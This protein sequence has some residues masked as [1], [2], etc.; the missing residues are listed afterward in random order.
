M[1]MDIES[2]EATLWSEN[3]RL[4]SENEHLQAELKCALQSG[5]HLLELAEQ[6]LTA[7]RP[8]ADLAAV[9]GTPG[10]SALK[11]VISK[12]LESAPYPDD[13][14]AVNEFCNAI[15][16]ARATLARDHQ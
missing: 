16:T 15:L 4:K 12:M 2:P 3:M 11:A 8:F 14:H 5:A 13:L 9:G 7:L 1:S 6:R 10:A